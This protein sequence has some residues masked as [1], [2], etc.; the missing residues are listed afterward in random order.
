M[1]F[2]NIYYYLSLNLNFIL[3]S[4]LDCIKINFEIERNVIF[5]NKGGIIYFKIY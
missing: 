3:L 2:I 4:Q 1:K 5:I